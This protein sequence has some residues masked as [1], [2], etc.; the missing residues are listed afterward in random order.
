MYGSVWAV[1]NQWR[2]INHIT[3]FPLHWTLWTVRIRRLHAAGTAVQFPSY[4]GER[5]QP[6]QSMTIKYRESW[7]FVAIVIAL[8]TWDQWQYEAEQDKELGVEENRRDI[9]LAASK[10]QELATWKVLQYREGAAESCTF[11]LFNYAIRWFA[12][13]LWEKDLSLAEF[14]LSNV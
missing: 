6:T 12:K 8:F 2:W 5:C 14:P 1:V 11:E 13:L 10:S 4:S 3:H 9:S 7:T